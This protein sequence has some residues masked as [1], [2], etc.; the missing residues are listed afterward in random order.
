MLLGP[1]I[2]HADAL[3]KARRLHDLLQVLTPLGSAIEQGARKIGARK[4]K[5]YA[6][7]A[8]AGA[9]INEWPGFIDKQRQRAVCVVDVRS[10]GLGL[11][12]GDQALWRR[13]H[14]IEKDRQGVLFHVKHRSPCSARFT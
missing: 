11:G 5:R 6:R 2:A 4:Q 10:E 13:C 8:R 14:Q 3:R 9:D 1:E 7:K 12:R